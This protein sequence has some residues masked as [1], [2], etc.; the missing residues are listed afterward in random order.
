[1][2][3]P[4]GSKNKHA[5]DQDWKK[6]SHFAVPYEHCTVCGRVSFGSIQPLGF[7]KWRHESCYPG[8]KS[9]RDYFE[10][11]PLNKRTP[12]GILIYNAKET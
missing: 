9:W 11:L 8:S 4:K 12:E 5:K 7:N 3:R 2:S 10:Q 1:M 6:P